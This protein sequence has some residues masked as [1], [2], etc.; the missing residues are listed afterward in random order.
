[1]SIPFDATSFAQSLSGA[2]AELDRAA[3]YGEAIALDIDRIYFVAP[4]APNRIM[5]GMRYWIETFS[6]KLEVRCYYPAEFMAMNP[7]RLDARTLVIMASKS[8]KTLESVAAAQFFQDMPCRKLVI[9]QAADRPIAQYIETR[10][11]LGETHEPFYGVFMI[12]QALIGG[13]L[14]GAEGWPHL[15]CLLSSLKA[16]PTVLASTVVQ[17]D[18]RAAKE[19]EA[20]K[21]DR[22]VYLLGAGPVFTMTYYVGV[23]ILQESQ[24]MHCI[25]VEAAEFF[26]GPFEAID[27]TVPVILMLGEDASRP[28]TERALTFCQRFTS[29]TIVYDS[30]DLPMPGIDPIV[31]P[32]LAPYV[33]GIAVERIAAHLAEWHKQPLS[34]TRY[35]GKLSY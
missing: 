8:G 1:M 23:C 11:L 14:A 16:L 17:Q 24:W 2:V 15:S 27:E 18:A 5:Q 25:P 4:G 21:D 30:R 29:R 35:M 20:Y 19:A 28:L 26:H 6:P 34:T 32:M 33:L 3:A 31:R 22:V 9:T 13:I 12:L 10:F 7:P